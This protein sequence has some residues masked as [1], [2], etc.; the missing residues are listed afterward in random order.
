MIGLQSGHVIHVIEAI[1]GVTEFCVSV[2]HI[3]VRPVVKGRRR[4]HVFKLL[5]D[6]AFPVISVLFVENSAVPLQG[7]VR[8]DPQKAHRLFAAV[9]KAVPPAELPGQIL[10]V[11]SVTIGRN[12]VVPQIDHIRVLR[13]GPAPGL[14]L[15]IVPGVPEHLIAAQRGSHGH[16][17]AD[18]VGLH[19]LLHA[20][21]GGFHIFCGRRVLR[22]KILVE[23]ADFFLRVIFLLK[24]QRQI[25]KDPA[26]LSA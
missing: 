24:I 18:P 19:Q 8:P 15:R 6:P 10:L 16:R 7:F 12:G 2:P 21:E 22:L 9:G 25:Q 11:H 5:A 1:I 20:L 13:H 26:V 3:G 14:L 23:H 4:P 17:Q